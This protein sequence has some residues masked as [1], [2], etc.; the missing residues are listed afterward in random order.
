MWGKGKDQEVSDESQSH[1]DLVV[2]YSATEVAG[3]VQ[4][5]WRASWPIQENPN[6]NSGIQLSR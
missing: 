2:S 5:E 4:E 6:I 1:S 3:H